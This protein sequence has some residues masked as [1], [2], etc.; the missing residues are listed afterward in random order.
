MKQGFLASSTPISKL[1]FLFVIVFACFGITFLLGTILGVILFNINISELSSVLDNVYNPQNIA[2]LKYFQILQTIGLFVIPP[3]VIAFLINRNPKTYLNF[4]KKSSLEIFVI[5]GFAMLLAL[6]VINFLAEINSKMNLPEYLS[7]I[8]NWMRDKEATAEELT[9]LF[10]YADSFPG[11]L[12]NLFMIAVLPAIGEELIFRG[13][14]QRLLSEAF[15]NV[16][17][18]IIVASF[19]FSAFHLQFYGFIPRMLL[20]VFLGYLL[21]WS[22]NIWIPIFAHFINNGAAVTAYYL[23]DEDTVAK[24]LEEVGTTNETIIFTIISALIVSGLIY[25]FKK[26]TEEQNLIGQ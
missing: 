14:I 1:L 4:D 18:G 10:V 7:G 12:L 8:E 20:G 24:N 26:K 19:I 23:L 22:K 17:W 11:Y 2:I 5:A 9:K 25:F 3:F 6:P 21:V 15:N 13:V 16:H